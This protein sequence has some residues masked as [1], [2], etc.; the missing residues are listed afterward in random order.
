MKHTVK[1]IWNGITTL[2]VSLLAALVLISRDLVYDTV[3]GNE[4][5]EQRYGVPVIGH[6]PDAYVAE[7]SPERYGY[8]MTGGNRR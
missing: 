8:K 5:I 2:L 6:I 4:E 3:Q 1:R 7:R